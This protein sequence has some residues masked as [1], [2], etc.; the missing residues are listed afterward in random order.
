MSDW[1]SL[2]ITSATVGILFGTS[3]SMIRM[4]RR[5]LRMMR[6]M[7]INGTI[8]D[9]VV[10]ALV[11]RLNPRGHVDLDPKEVEVAPR[12]EVYRHEDGTV[13]ILAK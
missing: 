3:L 7:A 2:V 4:N 9:R 13:R 5:L 8:Q 12:P 6:E 11:L 10:S 1:L